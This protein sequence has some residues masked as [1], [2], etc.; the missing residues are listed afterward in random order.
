MSLKK[1]LKRGQAT[2]EYFIIFGIIGVITLIGISTFLN[3]ASAEG[4]NFFGVAKM[5][6]SN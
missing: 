2:L 3:Q 4:R 6:I 5:R 1:N